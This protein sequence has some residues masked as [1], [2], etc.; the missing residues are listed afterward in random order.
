M[1]S[2][3]D[4][5]VAP[6]MPERYYDR[7][8]QLLALDTY[9]LPVLDGLPSAT[10]EAGLAPLRLRDE[11]GATLRPWD[12][13]AQSARILI[14]GLVGSGKSTVLRTLCWRLLAQPDESFNQWLTFKLFKTSVKTL[15]PILVDLRNAEQTSFFDAISASLARFGFPIPREYIV[16]RLESGEVILLVDH[17]ETWRD[18]QRQAQLLD[19]LNTY[20]RTGCIAVAR[21]GVGLSGLEGFAHYRL[22]GLEEEAIEPYIYFNLGEHS[23]VTRGLLAARERSPSL[24]HMMAMPLMLAAMCRLLRTRALQGPRLPQLLDGCLAVLGGEWP[25][26]L[27]RNAAALAEHWERFLSLAAYEMQRRGRDALSSEEWGACYRD[28]L[29]RGMRADRVEIDDM[30]GA[31]VDEVGILQPHEEGFA[32]VDDLLRSYLAARWLVQSQQSHSLAGVMDDTRW[33]DTIVLVAGLLNEPGPFL[34]VVDSSSRREPD[35]WLLLAAC[36]AEVEGADPALQERVAQH[37]FELLEQE[38]S[39]LW[40]AAAAAVAGMARRRIRDHFTMLVRDPGDAEVRR[41]AALVMG[42]LRASWAVPS[43]GAAISD[44]E[45]L[46][47]QQAI[48]ALGHI[49]SPQVVHV[50]PRALRS[51]YPGVRK[52]AAEALVR[53]AQAPE[54][55]EAVVSD[56]ISALDIEREDAETVAEAERALAQIGP[57]ATE[58]LIAALGNRRLHPGQ[59][60]RVAR[61][62]GLL[63]DDRALPVLVEAILSEPLDQAGGYIDA[64]ACIGAPAVGPLI[65][66]LEGRDLTTGAGL[67]RALV[68]I[69]K[70]AVGPLLEAIAASAPEVRRAAV[71]AL[72]DIGTPAIEP[73]T[74]AMLHDSRFEVR[75]RALEI[76]AHIREADVGTTLIRALEDPDPGVRLHAVRY[77]GQIEYAEATPALIDIL[78]NEENGQSLRREAINSLSAI[79]DARAVNPLLEILDDP[80][81]REAAHNALAEFGES[82]V[83]ALI[84]AL[85]TTTDLERRAAVWDILERIGQ[86]GRPEDPTPLGLARIYALLRMGGADKERIL[87]LTAQMDW[88]QHGRELHQSL[89][90]V[91]AVADPDNLRE[92]SEFGPAFEWLPEIDVWLRPHIRE[93]LWGLRDVVE[94]INLYHKITRRD[95]QRDALL[96]AI[97]RLEEMREL[98]LTMALPFEQAILEPAIARWHELMIE[99]TKQLRGRASLLIRL[100]T[101]RLPIRDARQR[102]TAV[103]SLFNEGDSAARN[104]SVSLRSMDVQ[105]GGLRIIREEQN[106][107]PLGIGEERQVE[108]PIIPGGVQMAELLLVARYDDDDRQRVNDRFSCRIEF[109][110]APK[111]YTPITENPYIVG[112]P[113]RESQM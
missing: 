113:V 43:L 45:P 85:H 41:R 97:D 84:E 62:L 112:M 105:G 108:V 87:A 94:D 98:S 31:L 110:P 101:P 23:S 14:T 20:P 82:A 102:T 75:R 37:V 88:W 69:G 1:K 74:H 73:L 55:V 78:R 68:K 106:L 53:Q 71:H 7:Y 64:V 58:Q 107:D 57:R 89:A 9:D 46:V 111:A 13:L 17:L 15:R 77:L 33:R 36:I 76:L 99:T 44:E 11:W 8:A 109:Y 70:P 19:L 100:L 39:T 61:T 28:S 49:P 4:P 27:G 54:L 2:R 79:G 83:D 40:P 51:P 16:H 90:T 34:Q 81:L 12:A 32:F 30:I 80:S 48:W 18:P 52:A 56:L 50:L 63:G 66:A 91:D 60:G 104:L 35:K 86:R 72:G 96:S 3:V 95:S 29:P 67:I 92:L 26:R 5:L 25:S 93:I 59:R 21:S 65:K 24:S 10:L 38:D 22:E 47:R 6:Y 42:R 103:F